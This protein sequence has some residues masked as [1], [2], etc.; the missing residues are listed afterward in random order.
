VVRRSYPL[1]RN[2]F[3]LSSIGGL[4]LSECSRW[5]LEN[6]RVRVR[7]FADEYLCSRVPVMNRVVSLILVWVLSFGFM[8]AVIGLAIDAPHLLLLHQQNSSA[9]GRVIR[10]EP[11]NHGVADVTYVVGGTTYSGQFSPNGLTVPINE[12]A[13]VRVYY[14]PPDPN[15]AFLA[16]AGEMLTEELPF[17]ITGSLFFS[18]FVTGI[19]F[20]FRKSA[21]FPRF[22]SATVSPKYIS[23]LVF[24]GVL[25]SLA[26]SAYFH[27]FTAPR[28]VGQIMGLVGSMIFLRLAWMRKMA[29]GA[30]LRSA[31]FWTAF[32]VALAGN[33]VGGI[34]SG[35]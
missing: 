27:I 3:V 15:I 18:L 12:G 24:C 4:V 10:V 33:I 1:L 19:V 21:N 6:L 28:F 32:V 20:S 8:A 17:W 2:G 25:V 34:F 22:Y 11:E 16:P 31:E 26:L 7:H 23:A 29:W 30:I 35:T 14:Y 5:L 9:L 13:M